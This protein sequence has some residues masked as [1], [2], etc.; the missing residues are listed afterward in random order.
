[1]Y[2]SIGGMKADLV[3][4]WANMKLGARIWIQKRLLEVGRN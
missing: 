4:F 2:S 3:A 1:M